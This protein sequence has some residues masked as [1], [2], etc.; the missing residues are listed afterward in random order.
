MNKLNYIDSTRGLAILMVMIVHSSHK[1]PDLSSIAYWTAAYGQMGVQLFFVASAFTLSLSAQRR[2]GE[3]RAMSKYWIRRIARIAPMY[4]LGILLY[5]LI[6]VIEGYLSNG[7]I[8]ILP[9]YSWDNILSNVFFVHG[10]YPPANNNI[11]PGGWSIGTEMAFYLIFPF[12]FSLANRRLKNKSVRV[13]IWMIS[14]YVIAQFLVL[15]LNNYGLT[16][17]RNS[18]LYYNLANQLSLFVIGIGY[19]FYWSNRKRQGRALLDLLAVTSL[20]VFA[21]WMMQQRLDWLYCLIPFV[22]GLSFIFLIELLRKVEVLNQR[23]LIRIGQMSYSMYILHFFFVDLVR[24]VLFPMLSEKITPETLFLAVF[25]A[26]V[27]TTYVAALVT[28]R[29]VEKPFVKLGRR[30]IKKLDV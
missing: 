20:T 28:E 26:T 22:S 17:A 1:I 9:K 4:Y 10:F 5:F 11:V 21:I 29:F 13:L 25:I 16:L 6:S 8:S 12:L 23:L 2:K 19:Y 15:L 14:G 7:D 27:G 30:W 3:E 18:F 24:I